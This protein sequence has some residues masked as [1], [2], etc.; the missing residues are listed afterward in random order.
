[1]F[2]LARALEVPPSSCLPESTRAGSELRVDHVTRGRQVGVPVL[3][4]I[5]T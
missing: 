1:M 2:K 3:V 4:E 5:N